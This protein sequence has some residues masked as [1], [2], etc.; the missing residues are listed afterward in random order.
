MPRQAPLPI[1]RGKYYVPVSGLLSEP[2]GLR[3]FCVQLGCRFKPNNEQ[4]RSMFS[5][6]VPGGV[7][8][9]L[10]LDLQGWRKVVEN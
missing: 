1:I 6:L 9:A 3:H 2:V 4:I 8:N 7:M 5:D 10:S